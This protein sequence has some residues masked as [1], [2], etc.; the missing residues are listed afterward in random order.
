M[1]CI[2]QRRRLFAV[3]TVQTRKGSRRPYAQR[4]EA[5]AWRTRMTPDLADFIAM[6]TSV[7]LATA[8]AEGRRIARIAAGRPSYIDGEIKRLRESTAVALGDCRTSKQC[9]IAEKDRIASLR[10][11]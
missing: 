10:L 8:S 2:F 9:S 7:F 6:Q 3:K 1:S 5:G 11:P 4:E